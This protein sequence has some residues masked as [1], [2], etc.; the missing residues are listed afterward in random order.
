MF[1]LEWVLWSARLKGQPRSRP[2]DYLRP[3]R[4]ARSRPRVELLEDRRLL[5]G[6][7]HTIQHVVVIMQENR[8]FDEYFGT[9]PGADGIPDGVTVFDPATGQY[10]APYYT[11]MDRNQGASHSAAA[12][13]TD[14][15]GG[16]M[17]G[18]L[19]V[20]RQQHPTGAPEVMGY[21]DRREIPNYWAYADNFVL[22]DQMFPPQIGP[23]QPSH[24]FLVSG[25]SAVCSNPMDPFT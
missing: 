10:V 16:L 5:A 3:R 23:S 19:R 12:A 1:R 11:H 15:D 24:H 20:Y 25:W 22:N 8:S 18:F 2:P 4:P 17:D 6:D 7:I 21:H 13:R 14:I 9:Y